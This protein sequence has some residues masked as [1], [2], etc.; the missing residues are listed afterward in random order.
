MI[1]VFCKGYL[2]LLFVFVV[3]CCVLL[4]CFVFLL[5]FFCFFILFCFFF[6]L[7]FF[8]LFVFVYVCVYVCV[9]GGGV[10]VG[11][12]VFIIYILGTCLGGRDLYRDVASGWSNN[13]QGMYQNEPQKQPLVRG[14]SLLL[15]HGPP[16]VLLR[17]WVYVFLV[18]YTD[19]SL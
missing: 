12:V 8:V 18:L 2:L 4:F 16:K 17:L 13:V 1:V 15:V 3:C 19:S 7:C 11:V 6:F 10:G 5:L 9:M 14:P